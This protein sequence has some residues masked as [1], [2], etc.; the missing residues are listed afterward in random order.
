MDVGEGVNGGGV[1]AVGTY[2]GG[3]YIT[4]D[5]GKSWIISNV[6]LKKTR[7]SGVVFSPDYV[8]DQ[9]LFAG[10]SGVLLKSI[11]SGKSWQRNNIELTGWR[12]WMSSNLI[13]V[14]LSS[15]AEI[16]LPPSLNRAPYPVK[17]VISPSYS[18]D[19][20]VYFSTREHGVFESIDAG[21]T[22]TQL[23]DGLNKVVAE[24][25]ISPN[26][27]DDETLFASVR[28][29][30]IYKSEDSGK[31]WVAV[32]N[33]LNV[34]KDWKGKVIHGIKLN[35]IFLA[36]SSNYANDQTLFA[37]TSH[38]LYRTVNGGKQWSKIV[39]SVYDADCYINAVAISPDYA[40][41][42]TVLVSIKGKGLYKSKNRGDTF[43]NWSTALLDEN[44]DV[45]RILFSP[46][47]A[48]DKT[49]YA[50]SYEDVFISKDKG[51]TWKIID[52]PVR[53][54]N[55]REVVRYS[56]GWD[57]R[58]GKEYSANMVSYSESP[59]SELIL[60]FIGT[61]VTWIGTLSD[62]QGK[63]RVYIDSQH[64]GEIDQYARVK[65]VLVKAYTINGLPHGAHSIRIEV[66]GEK[67]PESRGHRIDVDA[68]DV[69]P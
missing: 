13:K 9:T 16:V 31:N 67:N 48:V 61:G 8:S 56:E 38:G 6:G 21:A 65:E 39:S 4:E 3:G 43:V 62:E 44:H 26:F 30:G 2:G 17:V 69:L 10:A 15:L 47:Y 60:N 29:K 14:G 68:F 25:V 37:A 42:G 1:L 22:S 55:H 33:G 20:R 52:R 19:K 57:S 28:G 12:S 18:Q 36:I 35:D 51:V 32:N 49:V 46:R 27:M 59:G 63:A 53:Y 66:M 54:E 41:D 64:K 45:S 5:E 34:V 58:K 23:W 11:N 24:L 7:L 50:A 40:I